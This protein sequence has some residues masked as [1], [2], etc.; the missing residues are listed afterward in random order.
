VHVPADEAKRRLIEVAKMLI[1]AADGKSP[2]LLGHRV[3]RPVQARLTT[4]FD[5]HVVR[6]SPVGRCEVDAQ[7]QSWDRRVPAMRHDKD[8]T[9]GPPARGLRPG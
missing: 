3:G 2:Y 8:R 1:D 4:R 5:A 7:E 9:G 6:Q